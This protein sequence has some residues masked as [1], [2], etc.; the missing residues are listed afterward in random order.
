M[1]NNHTGAD[2]NLGRENKPLYLF[3]PCRLSF[4]VGESPVC[5]HRINSGHLGGDKP[6]PRF[7]RFFFFQEYPHFKLCTKTLRNAFKSKKNICK[8]F[9]FM[10]DRLQLNISTVDDHCLELGNSVSLKA[11][12]SGHDTIII[13]IFYYIIKLLYVYSRRFIHLRF[14]L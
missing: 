12:V 3:Q 1:S 2:K 4:V 5:S 7:I 14:A 13:T 6:V 9:I 8:L 11:A 10:S